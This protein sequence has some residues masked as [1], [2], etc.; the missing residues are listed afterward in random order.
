MSPETLAYPFLFLAVFFEAFVL[1]TFLSKPAKIARARRKSAVL[2]SV[3]VIVPCYNEASTVAGT[4]ESLLALDY[5]KDKLEIILVDDG[6]TD[7]TPAAMAK[8]EGHSQVRILRKENGGKH[9]ALNAAIQMTNAEI[10][11]CLDADSFVEPDALK[12]IVPCFEDPKVAAVTAAMSVH[13]PDN[14]LR[15]MQNAEYIFGIT[16]RHA[17][18][19]VNGL[20]V[21]PGPFSF[22]RHSILDKVGAFRFGHQTEDMEMA[23]RLQKKGYKIDNAPYARVYTKAPATVGSLIRQRTRWTTGFIRNVL[24]E[25]RG[26]VGNPDYGALGMLVLPIGITAIASGIMLFS[27]SVFDLVRHATQAVSMRAGVPL[28]YSLAP[29]ASFDWFYF[30]ASFYLLLAALTISATLTLIVI[31]KRLSKTPGNLFLGLVS[32][33]FLYGFIAPLWLLRAAGD[34][35]FRRNRAWR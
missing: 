22:Y 7:A 8:F 23:L 26:L 32:Y 30:P 34:A 6:S 4:A 5:P 27:V 3:A 20:Y 19:S 15:Q 17:L 1:V 24:G 11:G 13:K 21:T 2:P 16:L 28:S 33:V 9:T 35:M 14:V 10:I 31:G 18:A 25:Y 29:H 12:E